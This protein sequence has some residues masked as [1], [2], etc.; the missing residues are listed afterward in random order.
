MPLPWVAWWLVSLV[1]VA[2]GCHADA[3]HELGVAFLSFVHED[4]ATDGPVS[5]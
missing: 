3:D 5:P 2:H 1:I 4:Q